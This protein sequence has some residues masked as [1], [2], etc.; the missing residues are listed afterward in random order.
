MNRSKRI[1]SIR[2]VLGIA[3]SLLLV[4]SGGSTG[5]AYSTYSD[6]CVDCH[7]D[8]RG[9]TSPKGTVFPSGQNHE[10]HRASTSMGTAC[11]L[12]HYGTSR[13][14]VYTWQSTG[15]ANNTGLG[16]SGCHVGPGLR[17]HHAANGVADCYGCHDPN[18]VAD[19]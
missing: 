5:Q 8:F 12:C 1:Q 4:V 13:T 2:N 17:K 18:E 16:C 7:G 19:P 9:P 6:G 10:M 14:P 15:T 3:V 11:N